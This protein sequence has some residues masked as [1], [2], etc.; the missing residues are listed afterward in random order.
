MKRMIIIILSYLLAQ[1]H[2][3]ELNTFLNWN[4]HWCPQFMCLSFQVLSC[5]SH[6]SR[7]HSCAHLPLR[8]FSLSLRSILQLLHTLLPFD[9]QTCLFWV[10]PVGYWQAKEGM[11]GEPK[12]C[13]FSWGF[14]ATRC[15]IQECGSHLHFLQLRQVQM[16]DSYSRALCI[17]KMQELFP[18]PCSSPLVW[19]V[20]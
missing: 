1:D 17:V 11:H 12:R 6:C 18:G 16:G 3:T 2:R 20:L 5:A 7:C 4:S 14:P 15:W 19:G 13:L 9:N 8:A 10:L